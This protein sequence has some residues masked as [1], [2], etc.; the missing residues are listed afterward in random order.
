[1]GPALAARG[2]S[3]DTLGYRPETI[4]PHGPLELYPG[5]T[6]RVSVVAAPDTRIQARLGDSRVELMPDLPDDANPGRLVFD[7]EDPPETSWTADPPPPARGDW[8][9]FAGDLFLTYSAWPAIRSGS[10]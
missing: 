5:D 9:R 7:F 4:E 10:S 1:M 8:K 3:A 2:P 6:L